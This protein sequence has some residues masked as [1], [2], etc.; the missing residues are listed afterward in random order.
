[1]SDE[2]YLNGLAKL[3]EIDGAAGQG[4]IDSLAEIAPDLAR[5]TIEFPFGDVY[6]R[7][8]LDL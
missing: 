3:G 2:R 7:P 4:V 6:S 5:Y 8:A 1:M